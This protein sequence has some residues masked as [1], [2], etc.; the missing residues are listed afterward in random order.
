[1]YIVPRKACFNEYMFVVLHFYGVQE[2]KHMN[3][4]ANK[5]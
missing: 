5:E 2:S 1:M 3:F 4:K